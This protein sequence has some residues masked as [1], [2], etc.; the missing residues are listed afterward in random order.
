MRAALLD[1][2]SDGI[3]VTRVASVQEIDALCRQLLRV[4]RRQAVMQLLDA[5]SGQSLLHAFPR[6]IQAKLRSVGVD[7]SPESL[8]AALGH[9]SRWLEPPHHRLMRSSPSDDATR[10]ISKPD[11]NSAACGTPSYSADTH[12][13]CLEAAHEVADAFLRSTRLLRTCVGV[14]VR[15]HVIHARAHRICSVFAFTV[16]GPPNQVHLRT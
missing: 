6:Y 15:V 8:G 5:A 14:A 1:A 11:S 3:P 13:V 4:G 10:G 7:G 16:C 2:R 9:D 12:D